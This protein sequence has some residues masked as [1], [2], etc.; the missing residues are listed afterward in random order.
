LIEKILPA[1]VAAVDTFTDPPGGMLFPEEETT[2]RNAVEKRRMEFTTVR[3][4]AR[5]AL[6]RLGLPPA[7]IVPGHRGVPRWPSGVVGS[8]THCAGY[9]AA[10]VSH[11]ADVATIGIDAEPDDILPE[12]VLKMIAFGDE[13]IMLEKL[14][15][16]AP[17]VCWDR[18]LFSAKESVYKAWFPLTGR[19]LGFEEATVTIDPLTG[20]FG[21]HLVA[22]G[23]VIGGTPLTGFT[24]RWMADN[25]LIITAI[26]KP[27]PAT[28]ADATLINSGEI[29]LT[30]HG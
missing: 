4:C 5:T 11:T 3:V 13:L 25:G 17:G 23:P 6:A 19:W 26:V 9:R 1:C 30:R 22:P 8:M 29:D 20:R 27:A 15:A 24:G 7:P 18:L 10:A 14:G 2:V 16:M 12:G 21:A 28:R